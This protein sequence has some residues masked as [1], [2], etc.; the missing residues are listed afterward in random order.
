MC[1]RV[2]T[3][4]E[5]DNFMS[6]ADVH[7]IDQS[8]NSITNR[9]NPLITKYLENSFEDKVEKFFSTTKPDMKQYL[10]SIIIF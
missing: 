1:Q 5:G 10:K 4:N 9:L 6:I 3:I 7:T 2:N 8:K